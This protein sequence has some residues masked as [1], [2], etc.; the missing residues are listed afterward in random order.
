[1]LRTY[2]GV[3]FRFMPELAPMEGFDHL[4][5]A[6]HLWD[7]WTHCTCTVDQTEPDIL[8]RLAAL[9]HDCGK[10]GCCRYDEATGRNRFF[11]HPGAGAELTR[12]VLERL[13]CDNRTRDT[14]CRL[15][16]FHEMHTDGSRRAVRRLLSALGEEDMGRLLALRRA[17]GMVHAPAARERILAQ[18]DQDAALLE[19]IS[20]EEGRLTLEKL[21]VKGRDLLSL[22]LSPGP[23]VG[24]VLRRLL[25]LVLDG[26]I[27][28]DREA[29]LDRARRILEEER[30]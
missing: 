16:A 25:T 1:M 22:G 7:V 19:E 4:N 20:A 8:L 5:P 6:A 10:P 13:R 29:L 24:E 28:N 15:V 2:P 30:L 11:G 3:F 27:Q 18:V 12:V 26:E 21:A 23:A 17:D 9:F 14:V